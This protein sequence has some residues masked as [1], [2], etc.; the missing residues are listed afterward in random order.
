MLAPLPPSIHAG[1]AGVV[2]SWGLPSPPSLPKRGGDRGQGTALTHD[3][4]SYVLS[5]MIPELYITDDNIPISSNGLST[6][7]PSFFP[8]Q[9]DDPVTLLPLEA[10]D[11][12]IIGR[13]LSPMINPLS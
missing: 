5:S 8:L 12:G 7:P 2:A 13:K 10:R 1:W 9:P 6:H 11:D 3:N 4:I